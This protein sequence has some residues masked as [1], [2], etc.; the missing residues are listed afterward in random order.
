MSIYIWL[1]AI[2]RVH[3]QTHVS[4]YSRPSS[5]F[6]PCG[7]PQPAEFVPCCAELTG[8]H[9]TMC[10]EVDLLA[11]SLV[12]HC[13]QRYYDLLQNKDY[14]IF[15]NILKKIGVN[16]HVCTD[17][18]SAGFHGFTPQKLEELIKDGKKYDM[19]QTCGPE[20]MMVK[21]AQ[22]A[23]EENILSE[24]S[25]ERYMKCG[26]GVCGQCAVDGEGKCMCTEGPIIEGSRA[27]SWEEFGKY[28]R[29]AT[30]KKC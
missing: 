1:I 6:A 14:V 11:F 23:E 3:A 4:S 7:M 27:L 12:V 13:V 26:F 22:I 10:L 8:L 28:H 15:E 21:I 16:V 20:I 24:V 9:S 17:D 5:R 19:I 2:H 30:G 25:I 29:G 18:G